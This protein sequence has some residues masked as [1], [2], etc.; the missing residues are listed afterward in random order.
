MEKPQIV[1]IRVRG[2]KEAVATAV[3]Q[4]ER[5]LIVANDSGNQS[6]R[7]FVDRYLEIVLHGVQVV[8]S[9]TGEI[10]P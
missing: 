3:A 6:R 10:L 1:K 8:D 5:V 9:E 2:D 7:G 4:I